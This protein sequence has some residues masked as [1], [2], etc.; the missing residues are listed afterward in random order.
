MRST[1]LSNCAEPIAKSLPSCL[2]LQC[3]ILFKALNYNTNKKFIIELN[4]NSN[5]EIVLPE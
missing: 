5:F 2:I 1:K 3:L 4:K